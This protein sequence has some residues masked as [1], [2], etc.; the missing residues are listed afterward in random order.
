VLR[1]Q[2]LDCV[3][4]R[5]KDQAILR[6]LAEAGEAHQCDHALPD[7]GLVLRN[8]VTSAPS[9]PEDVAL[10]APR[11][12]EEFSDYLKNRY[13]HVQVRTKPIEIHEREASFALAWFEDHF[14][15]LTI[16][17]VE[18]SARWLIVH[19]GNLGLSEFLDDWLRS[20]ERFSDVRWYTEDAWQRSERWQPRP[21]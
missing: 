12:L 4:Y 2:E 3:R 15:P 9:N 7:V 18:D 20:R 6:P 14:H 1:A 8:V 21:W 17:P 10:Q 19:R 16:R 5:G 13:P 11:M